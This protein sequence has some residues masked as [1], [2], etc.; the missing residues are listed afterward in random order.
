MIFLFNK[1]GE[2]LGE[3]LVKISD[4]PISDFDGSIAVE[5]WYAEINLYDFNSNEIQFSAIQFSQ[6][7]IKKIIVKS[8]E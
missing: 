6:L 8:F 3:N 7:V 2:V 4:W 1:I 5:M